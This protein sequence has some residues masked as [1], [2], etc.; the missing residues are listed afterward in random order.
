MKNSMLLIIGEVFVDTHLDNRNE[1]NEPLIRLGGIFHA[2]RACA[3]LGM[4]YALAYYAPEYLE[5][6]INEFSC[7]LKAKGCFKI[8]NIDNSPNVM[9]ISEST[10][11]GSQGYCNLLRGR[12][13]YFENGNI[14]SILKKIN[15][16]DALVFPGRYDIK[17]VLHKLSKD[18][19]RMHIDINYDSENIFIDSN[20]KFE[21]I[22]F[23]TSS[24]YFIKNVTKSF[25]DIVND[26]KSK[27]ITNFVLKENRG[28]SMCYSYPIDSVFDAPAFPSPAKHSVGA[29]DVF[30]V[31][32]IHGYFAE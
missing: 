32:F 15:P 26:F 1:Y 13:C 11:A 7:E 10:E 21:T 4:E 16:T 28:G 29:G 3:A 18:K 31:A 27:N 19:I 20:V 8:G 5:D 22:F 23:S 6:S 9:L 24:D 30:D 25:S 17:S 2:A 14:E 12:T